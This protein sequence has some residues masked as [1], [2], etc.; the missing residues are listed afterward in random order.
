MKLAQHS[1]PDPGAATPKKDAAWL[2]WA[3]F[4]A[5]VALLTVT[6][7]KKVFDYDIWYHLSIGREV[8]KRGAIP[9]SEF[10]VYTLQGVPTVFHAWGY[11]VLSHLTQSAFGFT[12]LSLMNALLGALILGV[13]FLVAVDRRPGSWPLA[14][15]LLV[16]VFLLVDFRFVYRPEMFAYLLLGLELYLL[17]RFLAERSW[18]HLYLVPLLCLVLNNLHPSSVLLVIV[19][20]LYAAQFAWE[21]WRGAGLAR[22]D[23]LKLSGTVAAALLAS[24]LNPYGPLPLLLPF[25]MTGSADYVRQVVELL[26]TLQTSLKWPAL[27]FAATALL[28]LAVGRRRPLDWLLLLFFGYIGFGY[29][30]SLPF[31]VLVMYPP[32][33]WVAYQ[34]LAR[35]PV[36]ATPAGTK[37]SWCAAVLALAG[38]M[39]CN[40]LEP[41]WGVGVME[42][43]FPVR[44]A[45]TIA[46]LKPQGRIFN[47]EDAGGYLGWRLYPEY[48]VSLDGRHFERDLSLVLT[49][50]LF[51]AK[52]GWQKILSDYQVTTVFTPAL[53]PL[54]GVLID[55]LLHLDADEDWILLSAEPAGLL[56]GNR[57]LVPAYRS[58]PMPDQN[59][60][61]RQVVEKGKSAPA[62]PGRAD[63]L[64]SVSIAY[65]MLHQ[66]ENAASYLR[67]YVALTPGDLE[68]AKALQRMEGGVRFNPDLAP[69]T[70]KLRVY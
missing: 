53:S 64:L 22:A 42:E 46:T 27:G 60:T 4:A 39:T 25:K 70:T 36:A 32:I 23:L 34:A 2:P 26:P 47:S 59:Q 35:L 8:L 20:C 18:K 37:V 45:E 6:L 44:A 33:V 49:S 63:A 1:P 16:P 48:Q 68:A 15:L 52:P 14:L 19:L 12:G 57:R 31:L 9:A 38:L 69:P 5:L 7:L 17:E 65:H 29:V 11:G 24:L 61:W 41:E 67:Q 10:L 30:R 13:F 28:A 21:S 56:F 58:F 51:E 66:F 54:T 55:L 43:R 50:Q 40:L 3:L 62:S